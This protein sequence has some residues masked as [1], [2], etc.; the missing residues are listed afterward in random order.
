M[1]RVDVKV[2]A[3]SALKR[4]TPQRVAKLLN[5]SMI[6]GALLIANDWKERAPYKTG[7]YRRSVHVAGHSNLTPGFAGE[8][9]P[10]DPNP[11]I[12]AV[13]TFIIDP[14]YPQFLEYGTSRMQPRP[15]AGPALEA[16]RDDALK[17]IGEAFEILLAKEM[18]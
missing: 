15:S 8:E 12:V 2:Q 11:L 6:S 17:E 10:E 7:T 5:T 18:A 4:L 13:G 1:L 16:T 9:I 14:P 3:H